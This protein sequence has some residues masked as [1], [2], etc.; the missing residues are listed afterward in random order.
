MKKAQRLD[1]SGLFTVF[2]WFEYFTFA[3]WLG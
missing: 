1:T 3:I 2:I